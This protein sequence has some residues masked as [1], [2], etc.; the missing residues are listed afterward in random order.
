MGAA[1][2]TTRGI[3]C[4][5]TDRG[6]LRQSLLCDRLSQPTCDMAEALL[7]LRGR[8]EGLRQL[9]ERG[10][11][12]L[13]RPVLLASVAFCVL[14]DYREGRSEPVLP[15][16]FLGA[17]GARLREPRALLEDLLAFRAQQVPRE[18]LARLLPLAEE[19]EAQ[20]LGVAGAALADLWL[21]ARAAIECAQV[22]SEVREA[23]SAGRMD[24]QQAA[25]LLAGT[26]SDQRGVL[27]AM[28]VGEE[29]QEAQEAQ[30]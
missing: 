6:Q 20:C 9:G 11:E 28:G 29:A 10:H 14:L 8:E 17:F 22:Y 15:A 24:Q 23:A 30:E 2:A 21:F 27:E 19:A 18:R 16:E 4:G 12:E 5:H 13:G 1:L 26:E 25:R 7:R 3:A